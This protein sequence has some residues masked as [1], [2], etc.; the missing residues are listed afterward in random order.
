[1]RCLLRNKR[2]FYYALYEGKNEMQDEYGNKTGEYELVYSNPIKGSANISAAQGEVQ[3]RQFG[4]SESYD[5]V[6]V[7]D[8]TEIPINEYSILWVDTVPLIDKGVL[9]LD[10]RGEVVTPHDYIVKKVARS[11]NSVS[12]AIS[13]VRVDG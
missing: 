2:D 9:V 4:E 10:E 7:L 13:K 6:I 3:S 12:I 8:N 5:K 1:M 11:L